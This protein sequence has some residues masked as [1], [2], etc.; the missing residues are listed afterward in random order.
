[1][2]NPGFRSFS[3]ALQRFLVATIV[4]L[5]GS[6]ALFSFEMIYFHEVRGISLGQAGLASRVF[7]AAVGSALTFAAGRSASAPG[8][9]PVAELVRI[10]DA[11]GRPG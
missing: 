3:P 9:L 7:G 1:M 5:M 2:S 8:Q 6:S 4:N 11:V 10:L